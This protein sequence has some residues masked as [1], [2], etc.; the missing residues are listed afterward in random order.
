MKRLKDAIHKMP[1]YEVALNIEQM[2]EYLDMK[3]ES[4]FLYCDIVFELYFETFKT[5]V[6]F[7]S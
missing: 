1:H 5:Y 7:V 6:Y 2:I 4:G 3:E